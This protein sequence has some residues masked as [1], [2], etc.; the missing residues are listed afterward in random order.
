MSSIDLVA[1]MAAVLV[2]FFLF[3]MSYANLKVDRAKTGARK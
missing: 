1:L 2:Q 3:M